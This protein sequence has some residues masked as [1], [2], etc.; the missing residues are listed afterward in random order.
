MSDLRMQHDDAGHRADCSTIRSRA[1]DQQS[2]AIRS[3][4]DPTSDLRD[5]RQLELIIG[6]DYPTID[7]ESQ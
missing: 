7:R 5:R 6:I 1:Y 2:S 3:A 4:D